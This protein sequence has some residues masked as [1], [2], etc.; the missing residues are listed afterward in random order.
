MRPLYL[1]NLTPDSDS[2]YLGAIPDGRDGTFETLKLMAAIVRHWKRDPAM[3]AEAISQTRGLPDKDFRGEVELLFQFVRDK[4]RYVQDVADVETLHTPDIILE[5]RAG[6]CDDKCILLCT[7]LESIGHKTRF[8][9]M[10]WDD[11]PQSFSHVSCETRIG[12]L[13]VNCETTENVDLGWVP[14]TPPT[15]KMVVN[16]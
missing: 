15:D 16:N 4:I 8:V 12:S 7:L 3:R 11:N 10:G 5:Q 14:P 2:T 9:A 1:Q 13:W 6:D